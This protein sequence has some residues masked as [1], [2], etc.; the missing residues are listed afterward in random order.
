VVLGSLSFVGGTLLVP[1][2]IN[3][4]PSDEKGSS[5]LVRQRSLWITDKVNLH[6]LRPGTNCRNLAAVSL[7]DGAVTAFKTD[8]I[9][10]SA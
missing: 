4:L 6:C 3:H 9:C 10:V 5:R 7:F 2:R 8:F 1:V